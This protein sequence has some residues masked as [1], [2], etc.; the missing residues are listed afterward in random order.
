MKRRG[1]AF[2][3][4][5]GRYTPGAIQGLTRLVC[6]AVKKNGMTVDV[7]NGATKYVEIAPEPAGVEANPSVETT[8]TT[9]MRS[10]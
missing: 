8:P 9:E 3:A 2:V 4:S 1:E 10:S 5:P 6:E 7:G